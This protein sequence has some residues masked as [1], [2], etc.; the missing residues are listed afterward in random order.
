MFDK[1]LKILEKGPKTFRELREELGLRSHQQA[2]QLDNTLRDLRLQKKIYFKKNKSTYNIKDSEEIIGT[3]R[4]T[5]NDYAF[6]EMDDFSVFIPGKFV[7]NA[8]EG[9]TV[10]VLLFPLREGEDPDRRAGKIVRV[11]QRNG[12]SIIGRITEVE[13][14]KQFS[15][16]ELV[17]K[18]KFE[19]QDLDKYDVGDILVTKFVDFVEGVISLQPIKELGRANDA[20]IDPTLIGYKFDFRTEFPNEVLE[21]VANLNLP[22]D[23]REDI[24]DRLIYTIDAIESKDLDDAVDVTRLENGNIRLGVHIADVSH[25]VKEESKIDIEAYERGTSVY[26]IDTVFPML[27]ERLS[28][29]LCSLNP[30]ELKLTL[31][32]DMEIDGQG[33]VVKS[34]LYKSKMISKHRLTYKQCDELYENKTDSIINKEVTDSLILAKE[35]SDIVRKSKIEKGMIDF[36]LPEAKVKLDEQGEVIEIYNKYQSPSEKVIE[37]LM[38]VTNE[39]VART[40]TEEGL[41]G[42]FRVHPSPKEENLDTFNIIAKSLGTFLPKSVDEIESKDLMKFLEEHKDNENGD[43]LKRYMIQTMEKAIYE[44]ED[45]GH[46]A[47]GLKNY[48]HF[49]SPIRRYPDLIIHRLVKRFFIDKNA[50]TNKA[51]A[52]DLIPYL[53]NA[54]KDTSEA[55]RIAVQGERRLLDIKKSRFL[56]SQVGNEM[57]GK[58]VSVVRFGFFVEFENLTQGLCHIENMKQDEFYYEETKFEIIGKESKVKYKLGDKVKVKITSVDVIKGLVDLE[59]A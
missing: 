2:R 52:E 46:Y 9:D 48:L 4:D 23:D 10:K 21:E 34:R 37:D 51:H 33:R 14:V 49:T 45:K 12:S 50:E 59:V 35:L 56:Q 22:E 19:L 47:L 27:P 8:L 36:V 18:Y 43:I 44:H 40:I 32:C 15:P 5:R 7:L 6:V 57:Y 24:T 3:F 16:D 20:T 26:L 38:V 41:P 54:A 39:T 53:E 29:E 11:M 30:D 31:S 13:G 58:I 42:M 1:V 25:Y 55:E 28:N 17:P